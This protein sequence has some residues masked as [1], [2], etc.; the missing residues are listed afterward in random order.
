MPQDKRTKDIIL[1]TG[2]PSVG[3]GTLV[4]ELTMPRLEKVGIPKESVE[5]ISVSEIMLERG[6]E[7]DVNVPFASPTI[8]DSLR[9]GITKECIHIMNAS[10]ASTFII[11]SPLTLVNDLDHTEWAFNLHRLYQQLMKYN[12]DYSNSHTFEIHSI[13][14]IIDDT[15]RIKN[16]LKVK[17]QQYTTDHHALL[18]WMSNE[19]R[20]TLI[21]S[22]WLNP[23]YR[24][25]VAPFDGSEE[26]L[27]KLILKP[28][29]PL[30]Y[31][32]YPITELIEREGD[33][34]TLVHNKGLARQAIDDFNKEHQKY[35]IML[36]P[37]TFQHVSAEQGRA[38]IARDLYNFVPEC[39]A[40]VTHMPCEYLEHADGQRDK[41]FSD[42]SF[43]E[44]IEKHTRGGLVFS[45]DPTSRSSPFS[46]LSTIPPFQST[47]AY[48]DAI[49]TSLQDPLNGRDL[50]IFIDSDTGKPWFQDMYENLK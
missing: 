22:P 45:I 50:S 5:A 7:A 40:V 21:D 28:E 17:P 25:L 20:H 31:S 48:F 29:A 10:D 32:S 18:T 27:L 4:E 33:D 3:K 11:Y 41:L 36:I 47:E 12:K 2:I 42:G 46:K 43:R 35:A 44:A 8:R 38:A 14:S 6:K 1:V 34:A 13:V 37:I 15:T 30:V 49:R 39:E 19:S 23:K 16:R 26:L 9:A 24:T